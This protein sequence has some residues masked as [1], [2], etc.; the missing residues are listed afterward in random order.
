MKNFGLGGDLLGANVLRKKF[1]KRFF[2][3]FHHITMP[4]DSQG[5]N[6][7]KPP[8]MQVRGFRYRYDG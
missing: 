4:A 6:E 5:S 7:S 2:G 1:T 8:S 3:V